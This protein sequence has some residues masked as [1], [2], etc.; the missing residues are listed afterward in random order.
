MKESVWV[1]N[2]YHDIAS[3]VEVL[4]LEIW[5][6][7][8]QCSKDCNGFMSTPTKQQHNT[9]YRHKEEKHIDSNS[10]WAGSRFLLAPA[11]KWT[12]VCNN[13]HELKDNV[14]WY[15]ENLAFSFIRS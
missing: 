1:D 13:P 7:C 6:N 9:T 14:R 8:Y 5:A 3:E 2:F 10:T 15:L 12:R 4:R 11:G